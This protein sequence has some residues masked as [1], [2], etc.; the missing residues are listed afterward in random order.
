MGKLYLFTL[1]NCCNKEKGVLLQ[2]A[3]HDQQSVSC[4]LL[5]I[6]INFRFYIL[7]C[8]VSVCSTCRGSLHTDRRGEG[9]GQPG[10]VSS[11]WQQWSRQPAPG[12]TEQ[13]VSTQ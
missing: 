4:S 3:I 10:S 8:F 2:N 7:F 9:S 13:G 11:A 12:R 1:H 5:L 6:V